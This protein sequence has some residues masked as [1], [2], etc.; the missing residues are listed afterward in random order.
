MHD[1]KQEGFLGEVRE[2]IRESKGL[3]ATMFAISITVLIQVGAFLVLWGGLTTT[4]KTHDKTLESNSQE[5]KAQAKN[6]D[7]ILGKLENINIVGFAYAKG[8]KGN[9][10]DIGLQGLQGIQGERGENIIK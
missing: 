10:G 3:K 9:K 4:V 7:R 2:F 8:D 5:I 6:I 1:C